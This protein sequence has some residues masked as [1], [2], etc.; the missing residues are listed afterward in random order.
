[1]ISKCYA[2]YNHSLKVGR[3]IQPFL[4]LWF[5]NTPHFYVFGRRSSVMKY[6]HPGRK[7]TSTLLNTDSYYRE[8][9]SFEAPFNWNCSSYLLIKS[10]LFSKK[11]SRIIKIDLRS[12]WCS[13]VHVHFFFFHN[14][15]MYMHVYC[16]FMILTALKL[17]NFMN[18]CIILD[19]YDM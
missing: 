17:F 11:I 19:L 16:H 9:E 15:C 7:L 10:P 1:M 3:W 12:S 14:N 2:E 4:I 6:F 5:C 18:V 8:S 13:S